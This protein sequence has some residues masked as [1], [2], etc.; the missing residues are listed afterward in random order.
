MQGYITPIKQTQRKCPTPSSNNRKPRSTLSFLNRS[1][2]QSRLRR[3][4]TT[5]SSATSVRT[6]DRPTAVATNNIIRSFVQR[7]TPEKPQIVICCNHVTKS[8][9]MTSQS[10]AEEK[11][12]LLEAKAKR[13]AEVK[14]KIEED[15][16]RAIAEA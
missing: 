13:Q 2:S 10:K 3:L 6:V 14:K 16:Q 5:P 4:P 15:K 11:A 9:L 1:T 7:N 12:R 8:P